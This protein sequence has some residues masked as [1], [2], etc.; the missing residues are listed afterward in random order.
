MK[1][2]ITIQV[3]SLLLVSAALGSYYVVSAAVSENTGVSFGAASSLT[4]PDGVCKK[5]TNNSSTGKQIYVPGSTAAEW[6]SFVT[7]PPSGVTL[8]AC[9]GPYASWVTDTHLEDWTTASGYD[10]NSPA[11]WAN[12]GTPMLNNV[13]YNNV[14]TIGNYLYVF[15]GAQS[16][17]G[18]SANYSR[19][20]YRAPL[21]NP[22]AWVNTGALLPMPV[23]DSALAIVGDYV[24]LFGGHSYYDAANNLSRPLDTILRAPLSNPT[25]WTDTGAHIPA[26]LANASLAVI[27]N[28]IYLFGGFRNNAAVTNIIYRAPISNPV[29]WTDS[30]GRLPSA[31]SHTAIYVDSNYVYLFG[32]FDGS[33]FLTTIYRA[34]VSSPLSF[35]NTGAALPHVFLGRGG[36]P[37]IFV[38][39]DYIY[40]FSSY[41]FPRTSTLARAPISDPLNWSD[42]GIVTTDSIMAPYIAGGHV[43]GFGGIM[44][45]AGTAYG[46]LYR[47]TLTA[48]P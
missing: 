9:R 13:S 17:S 33:N 2:K 35:S 30:G 42:V 22:S 28:Y 8:S 25:N 1:S 15:G 3:G 23:D 10:M 32:G 37:S 14:S 48:S 5:V 26:T 6:Q 24:Y 38:V 11:S 43:Y 20:I 41:M 40:M 7:R 4:G 21:S 18:Y 27:G 39:G 44:W 12:V 47:T 36:T 46:T 31:L 29:N 34:P 16:T 19:G 45:S